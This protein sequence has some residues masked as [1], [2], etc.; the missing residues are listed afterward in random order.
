MTENIIT[1]ALVAIATIS[2]ITLFGND[3][4]ALFG[5]SSDALAGNSS[6]KNRAQASNQTGETKNLTNFATSSGGTSG[7]SNPFTR[8][9]Y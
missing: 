1:V 8:G 3:I 9:A 5:V 7:G 6:V 4:R 2:I